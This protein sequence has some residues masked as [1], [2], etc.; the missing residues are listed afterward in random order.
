[1]T[2]ITGTEPLV[3]IILI[4]YNRKDLLKE[5]IESI[6]AQTYTNYELIVVDNYSNY[7]FIGFIESFHSDKIQAYQNHN[8]GTIAI[9]RNY[10]I[11]KAK[12]DY[13]AFCDD[14]DLWLPNKLEMQM[15]Y[16]LNHE[17]S[18]LCTAITLF[19]ERIEEEQYRNYQ[20]TYKLEPFLFNYIA[21]S[22]VLL[23]NSNLVVFDDDPKVNCAE[24]WAMWLKLIINGYKLYKMPQS[25]V[26][27][28]MSANNL[29]ITNSSQPQLRAIYILKKLK[30][31]YGKQF[32]TGLF[33]LA[34]IYKYI[35]IF[36]HKTKIINLVHLVIRK[37]I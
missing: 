23:K 10:G 18:L 35:I 11:K 8:N 16:M 30:K 27:Y 1:M 37:R 4:T 9:N 31:T 33:L 25:L 5:T 13:L 36:L 12:G 15:D 29:S 3:S 24:D 32:N 21:P 28:R 14:D 6:L 19:G 17:V 34:I 22:T 26:K 20:Y 7:D 2:E